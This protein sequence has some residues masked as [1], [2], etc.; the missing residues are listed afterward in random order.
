MSERQWPL[1]KAGVAT[2]SGEL[3]AIQSQIDRPL[4]DRI[5]PVHNRAVFELLSFFPHSPF[6]L[7]P[8]ISSSRP[9]ASRAPWSSIG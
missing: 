9:S 1:S 4:L 8:Q 7:I 6:E 2:V 5:E 3:G